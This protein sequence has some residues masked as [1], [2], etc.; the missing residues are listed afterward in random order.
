M[1]DGNISFDKNNSFGVLGE[2][3]YKDGN[4]ITVFENGAAIIKDKKG[5]V[6]Y[7]KKSGDILLKSKK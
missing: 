4:T 2:K 7:V 3:T 1:R 6:I 5:N